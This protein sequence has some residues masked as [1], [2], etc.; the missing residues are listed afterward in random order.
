MAI[1][2]VVTVGAGAV[3]ATSGLVEPPVN[4]SDIQS[5]AADRVTIPLDVSTGDRE[6]AA[7]GGDIAPYCYFHDISYTLRDASGTVI[8]TATHTSQ[9]DKTE[10]GHVTS[11]IPYNCLVRLRVSAPVSD[12]YTL[13][14]RANG[15][16]GRLGR[17][18]AVTFSHADIASRIAVSID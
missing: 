7:G 11:T 4:V 6:L 1:A 2:A 18:A 15:A 10:L 8:A 17:T 12:F 13:E 9:D 3:V 5:D 16:F 14:L